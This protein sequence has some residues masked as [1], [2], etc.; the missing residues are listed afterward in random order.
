MTS[1]IFNSFFLFICFF[2]LPTL[3]AY[4]GACMRRIGL[5]QNTHSH[6]INIKDCTAIFAGCAYRLW[7]FAC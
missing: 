6:K 3:R 7:N 5:Q 4:C 1:I 2:D